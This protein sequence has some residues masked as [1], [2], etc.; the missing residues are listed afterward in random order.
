[1]KWLIT[2]NIIGAGFIHEWYAF[3]GW[4]IALYYLIEYKEA[5]YRLQ[6]EPRNTRVFS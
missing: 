1:M 3:A 6:N 5:E 4:L 2:A